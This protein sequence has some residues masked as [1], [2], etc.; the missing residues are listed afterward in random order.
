MLVY[1]GFKKKC[2]IPLLMKFHLT[3]LS[4]RSRMDRLEAAF[5]RVP[6]TIFAKFRPRWLSESF[7][8]YK[9]LIAK[10]DRCQKHEC[11]IGAISLSSMQMNAHG[12]T[13]QKEQKKCNS[14]EHPSRFLTFSQMIHDCK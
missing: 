4:E 9:D 10:E 1:G 6:K 14:N 7:N 3:L 12:Y 11:T 8:E 13:I 2:K 5:I